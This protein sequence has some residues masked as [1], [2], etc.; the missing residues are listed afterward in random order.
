MPVVKLRERDK[1]ALKKLATAVERVKG[2]T[3]SSEVV[4][5]SIRFARSNID[6]FL[7]TI[8]EDLE[9]DSLVQ[10]MKKPAR[11]GGKT[12]ARRVDEYLYGN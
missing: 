4:G 3:S 9:G 12:D 8:L 10:M 6:E 11:R 5:L 7:E 2:E 1:D